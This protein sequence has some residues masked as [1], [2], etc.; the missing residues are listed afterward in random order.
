MQ[1][2]G[3][4]KGDGRFKLQF[5]AGSD[6]VVFYVKEAD[7][8]EVIPSGDDE[9]GYRFV[10]VILRNGSQ[11]ETEIQMLRDA[12]NIKDPGLR[13]LTAAAV[14]SVSSLAG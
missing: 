12:R 6:K 5:E 14:S 2:L 9:K 8:E 13:R 3:R 10:Q 11:V 4:G 1:S 7:V